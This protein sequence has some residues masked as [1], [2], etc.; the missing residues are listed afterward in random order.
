[1]IELPF[2]SLVD[3]TLNMLP[4]AQE[5]SAWRLT[6]RA[7]VAFIIECMLRLQQTGAI[8]Y[9]LSLLQTCGNVLQLPNYWEALLESQPTPRGRTT[10]GK[11]DDDEAVR[12]RLELR[13]IVVSKLTM[14]IHEFSG[15][16]WA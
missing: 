2:D 5:F 10:A 3:D 13:R 11:P 4:S 16:G 6:A 8:V 12:L 14:A 9:D 1:V 7:T 15:C